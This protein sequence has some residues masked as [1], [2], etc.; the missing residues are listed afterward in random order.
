MVCSLDQLWV[1]ICIL[2]QQHILLIVI[3]IVVIIIFGAVSNQTVRSWKVSF[4]SN[5]PIWHSYLALE[6][7]RSAECSFKMERSFNMLYCLF[8]SNSLVLSRILKPLIKALSKG[9]LHKAWT[10]LV[11]HHCCFLIWKLHKEVRVA[12][13][14]VLNQVQGKFRW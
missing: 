9:I 6:K 1:S 3:I 4:I 8:A 14:S 13:V 12:I 2:L 10:T 5:S 7:C 11:S